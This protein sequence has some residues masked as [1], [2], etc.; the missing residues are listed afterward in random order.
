MTRE[1]ALWL[2]AQIAHD[3][4]VGMCWTGIV[5]LEDGTYAVLLDNTV[6]AARVR[7]AALYT[8]DEWQARSQEVC[9]TLFA[10]SGGRELAKRRFC[11]RTPETK[12]S[13]RP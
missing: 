3:R 1:R 13:E 2:R 12:G 10:S 8:A 4:R 9:A 7:Q 6:S 5:A 11:V